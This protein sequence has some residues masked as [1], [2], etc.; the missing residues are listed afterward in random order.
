VDA[1]NPTA[2]RRKQQRTI[3]T[4]RKIIHAAL[5][6]F[7]LVGFEGSSTRRIAELA[8]VPHSLVLYHFKN[9]EDLWYNTVQETVQWYTRTELGKIGPAKAGDPVR[10]LKRI[11]TRYIRFSAKFPDFFRML[12]HENMVGS[13]RL[14]WLVNQHVGPTVAHVSELIRR[15]QA[16][17]AVVEGEP[18]TLVYLFLGTAT[19][20]YRS[21]REIELLTGARPDTESAINR[22]IEVCERLFFRAPP[23]K[24][25]R[26]TRSA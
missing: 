26:T 11:M 9:K 21:A 14:R 18:I 1:P 5:T 25:R 19:S 13:P 10:R 6:D 8:A 7:A 22:H 3:D 15:G 2:R 4:R 20:P 17:G 12:T 23:A 24:K 16:I